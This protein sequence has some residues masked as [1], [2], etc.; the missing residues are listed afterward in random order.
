MQ[1]MEI[2]R[3]ALDVEWR[4]LEIISENLANANVANSSKSAPYHELQLLSGPKTD[5]ASYLTAQKSGGDSG[6]DINKLDGVA[7]Y[8]LQ[9]GNAAPRLVHEPGNP[10]A[11]ANGMVSYPAIDQANQMTQMLQSTRAYEAD[12]VAMNMAREMYS[13][14][15]QLGGS[16]Q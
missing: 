1:A 4:R 11:D 5:F 8:G 2:S 12:L 15:L 9:P 16:S 3:T 13:K 6:I 7:V 14:A 10:L